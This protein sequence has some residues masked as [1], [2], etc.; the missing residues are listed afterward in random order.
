MTEQNAS[1]AST[2]TL[3]SRLKTEMRSGSARISHGEI[4]LVIGELNAK[5]RID[6]GLIGVGGWPGDLIAASA[7]EQG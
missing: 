5:I 2:L 6:R 7:Q 3:L 1:L 4:A